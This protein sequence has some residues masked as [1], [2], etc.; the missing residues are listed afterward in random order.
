[1][2]TLTMRLELAEALTENAASPKVLF[3]N[4]AKVIV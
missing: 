4:A 1:M 2:L 3:P